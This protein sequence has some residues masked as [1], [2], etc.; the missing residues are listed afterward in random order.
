MTPQQKIQAAKSVAANKH[1]HIPDEVRLRMREIIELSELLL[2][3]A[4]HDKGCSADID[5]ER[6]HC[7]CGLKRIMEG[8]K[9]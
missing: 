5:P 9:P 4:R 8:D 2:E 7:R 1:Y 3:Y 6:F